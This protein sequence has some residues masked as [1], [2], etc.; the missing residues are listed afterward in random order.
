MTSSPS[1]NDVALA[2][3]SAY[4][5]EIIDLLFGLLLDTVRER[6]P[7]IE[8]A[9]CGETAT[10][11]D[12]PEPS[13]RILQCQ[14]FWFQPI[15]LAEE[16]G[17]TRRG[18]QTE[19]ER[20]PEHVA[21]TFASTFGQAAAAGVSPGDI[22]DLLDTARVRPVI[23]AHPTEAKRVPKGREPRLSCRSE[24]QSRNHIQSWTLWKS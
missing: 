14:G 1:P 16:N 19:V 4:A 8:P 6:R 2:G 17:A 3:G 5:T 15:G 18:R 11:T 12:N 10:P 9:L 21:G 23:T 24:R 22:Q 20:G 13:L 7:E